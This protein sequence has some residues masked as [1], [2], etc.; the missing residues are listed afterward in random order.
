[1]TRA[2]WALAVGFFVGLGAQ[3]AHAQMVD[4]N[5]PKVRNLTVTNSLAV[6]NDLTVGDDLTV[7]DTLKVAV[8][9]AGVAHIQGQ[10]GVAGPIVGVSTVSGTQYNLAGTGSIFGGSAAGLTAGGT[11]V[12]GNVANGAAAIASSTANN[13]LLTA[14]L[15]RFIH[16]FYND[17]FATLQASVTSDG[18]YLGGF[19][20]VTRGVSKTAPTVVACS[21]T[22]A[23][24]TSSNGTA[25]FV[26]DVGTSCAGESTAVITLPAA[27]TGWICMCTSTTADRVLQQKVIPAASTTVVTIQN[28]VMSTGANGDFTDGADVACLCHGN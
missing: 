22:A 20:P 12:R 16:N 6:G 3:L 21:G 7:T 9:D 13:P 1:M 15:D 25:A 5:N 26:F 11:H 10:L 18:T 23:S 4:P 14:G 2:Q 27:T 28:I 19:G 24:I 17:N 8:L